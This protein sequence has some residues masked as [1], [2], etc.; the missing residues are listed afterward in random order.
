[1]NVNTSK[2]LGTS[3]LT[4]FYWAVAIFLVAWSIFAFQGISS[5]VEIWYGN[6]IFN[7][8]FLILPA[9]VYFAYVRRGDWL[10]QPVVSSFWPLPLIVLGVITYVIGFAGD[11]RLFMHIAAFGLIPLLG[12]LIL[13]H[14]AAYK[15]LFPLCFVVFAIPVGEQ[16]IPWLQVVTADLSVYLLKLSGI[17]LFRSGLYIEIPQGRFLVAE[18]CSGISFFIAS[19]VVGCVYSYLNFTSKTKKIGFVILSIVYPIIANAIRVYGIIMVGYLSDME[20]AVGADHLVYGWFFFA[21]VLITLLAIGEW[22][23]DK[24]S[25]RSIPLPDNF[26]PTIIISKPVIASGVGV[27]ILG[28]LWLSWITVSM[29]DVATMPAQYIQTPVAFDPVAVTEN[30]PYKPA[31][32]KPADVKANKSVVDSDMHLVVY[33][34]WFSG[35]DSELVSGLHRLYD[36][37]E[38]SLIKIEN[39]TTKAFSNLELWRVSDPLGQQRLIASFYVVDDQVFVDDVKTKLYQSGQTILG[40]G[41]AG[42]KVINSIAIPA[43]QGGTETAKSKLLELVDNLATMK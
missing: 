27:F 40:R 24:D 2:T 36:E 21:I 4:S 12:W 37:K 9:T 11:I 42:L 18:A 41:N 26:S 38:W 33:Q 25:P 39:V 15:L 23:R 29:Q 19:I 28:Q 14:Q 7:H 5:A 6:E 10:T 22:I 16:L 43:K 31:L 30:E 17:P 32:F 8:G 35:N 34:A 3:S 20:H 13:G 1:L